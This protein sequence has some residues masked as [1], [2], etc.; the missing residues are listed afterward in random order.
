MRRRSVIK[1][2][3]LAPIGVVGLG[4]LQ[5]TLAA[6]PRAERMPVLFVGHGSPMNAILD[7]RWSRAWAELGA[8][9]RRPAAILCVSAHWQTAGPMVTAMER[10]RTIHDFYGFPDELNRTVYPAPGS[11]ELAG[12]TKALVKSAP[13]GLDGGWGLD[14]GTWSVLARMFP[15]AD[16]PVFQLSLD[17]TKAPAWH[18]ELA[19][20]LRPLR[21]RGVLI[22]G[23]GNI[24]H[25]LRRVD[26]RLPEAGFDWAVEFDARAKSLID[27]GDHRALVEYDKL[28]P[29]ARLSI[30]TDEHYLPLLYALAVKDA[31]DPIAYFNDGCA[32][33]SISMRS[34]VIG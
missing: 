18:Y 9:L 19:R 5:Q 33:G 25:N 29:A 3:A 16:I 24:V 34:L 32:M 28:G 14:H 23:S 2:V 13:V 21:D 22:I 15:R 20:E 11:P 4:A 8:A 10:P 17:H 31:R 6:E 12:Q 27:S 7:N 1:A 26:R 30:P